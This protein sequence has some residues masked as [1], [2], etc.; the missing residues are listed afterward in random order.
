MNDFAMLQQN[1]SEIQL[2]NA[3]AHSMNAHQ[4]YRYSG[5]QHIHTLTQVRTGNFHIE[6][7]CDV[8]GVAFGIAAIAAS[9]NVACK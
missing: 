2:Q 3:T 4:Q 5:F 9:T 6:E 1:W 8:Y 7:M